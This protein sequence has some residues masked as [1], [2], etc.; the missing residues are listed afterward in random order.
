VVGAEFWWCATQ[1]GVKGL[2]QR[3]LRTYSEHEQRF[4]DF[5]SHALS[6]PGACDIDIAIVRM[7]RAL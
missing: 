5:F 6:L 4:K 1:Q 7:Q 2:G 3:V